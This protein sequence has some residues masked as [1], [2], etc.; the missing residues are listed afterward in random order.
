MAPA[1][2][3]GTSSEISSEQDGLAHHRINTI[4]KDG[5]NRLWF[6]TSNGVCWYD[7]ADFHYLEHDG[8]AGR[9]VTSI[10]EDSEGRIWFGGPHTLGYH[11]GAVF[12]DITTFIPQSSVTSCW[13]I[14]Q[15]SQGHLWISAE[16]PIR[17]DGVSFRRYG[18]EEGFPQAEMGYAVSQDHTGKV[19]LGRLRA[20]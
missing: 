18:E 3:T 8:I 7:G 12:R 2:S 20:R 15:D 4:S 9:T 5:Q 13:C 6:G 1:V 17:F 14:T 11:D 19:W 16:Y 10:Y